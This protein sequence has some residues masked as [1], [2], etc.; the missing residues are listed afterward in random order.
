MSFVDVTSVK[1]GRHV[2]NMLAVDKTVTFDLIW[3]LDGVRM[4]VERPS[5]CSLP[6]M[7]VAS[8]RLHA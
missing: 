3:V 4:C 1:E 2:F 6:Q 5:V 7:P 8:V